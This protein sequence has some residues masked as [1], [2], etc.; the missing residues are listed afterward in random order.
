MFFVPDAKTGAGNSYP[1]QKSKARQ[2][3]HCK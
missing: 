2:S 1:A 3:D